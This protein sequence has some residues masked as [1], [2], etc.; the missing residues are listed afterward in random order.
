MI[1]DFNPF[2][3]A[4]AIHDDE[5]LDRALIEYTKYRFEGLLDVLNSAE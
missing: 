5:T 1:E 4:H 2:R 3:E